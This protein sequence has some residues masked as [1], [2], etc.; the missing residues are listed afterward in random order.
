MMLHRQAPRY[1]DA[2]GVENHPQ[3]TDFV[4]RRYR[5]IGLLVLIGVVT[6]SGL[7]LLHYFAPIAGRRFGFDGRRR[8]RTCRSRTARRAGSK[9]SSLLHGR[10]SRACLVYSIRRHRIDDFRGRYRVWLAA[11]CSV[12]GDECQ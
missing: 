10:R 6:T 8:L 12:P 5:T 7:A 9:P 3:I 4:P 1:S 2:A 11:A